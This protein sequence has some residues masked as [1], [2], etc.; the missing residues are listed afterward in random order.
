M[1]EV[2]EAILQRVSFEDKDKIKSFLYKCLKVSDDTYRST[3]ATHDNILFKL[4]AFF[5]GLPKIVNHVTKDKKFTLGIETLTI[6]LEELAVEVEKEE[7]FILFHLK[8]L[9]KFS[10]RDSKLQTELKNVWA[11]H[12]EYAVEDQDFMRSIKTLMRLGLIDYRK[13]NLKN[14]KSLLVRYKN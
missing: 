13:G 3:Y 1:Q 8:D 9:G 11:Q 4:D 10:I 7:V 6:I 2:I 5:A 14:K 12:K